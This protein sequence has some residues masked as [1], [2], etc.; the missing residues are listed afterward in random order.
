LG[1]PDDLPFVEKPY[2]VQTLAIAVENA[3]EARP[4]VG[5]P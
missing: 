4:P 3:L 2:T 5:E 1:I